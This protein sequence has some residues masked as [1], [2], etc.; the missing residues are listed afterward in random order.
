VNPK[1][2]ASILPLALVIVVFSSPAKAE[3]YFG[4]RLE[5]LLIVPILGVQLGYDFE[6]FRGGRFG[7]RATLE[8]LVGLL[9]RGTVDA[10]FRFSNSSALSAGYLGVGLGVTLTTA[11]NSSRPLA[12]EYHALF[13]YEFV[14]TPAT[15]LYVEAQIGQM[16]NSL[17]G[18]SGF[19][20]FAAVAT[21]F[22]WHF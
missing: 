21:G 20:P 16:Q 10:T 4:A 3:A 13:G 12:S 14:L 5:V 6:D 22:N 2:I 9:N 19:L 17:S 8:S 15:G 11:T 18:N 1:R 7:V